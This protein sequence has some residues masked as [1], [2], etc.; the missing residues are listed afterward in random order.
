MTAH[1]EYALARPRISQVF[2]LAL[3]VATSE[4][5]GAKCLIAGEDCEVFDLVAA[6]VAAVCAVVTNKGAVAEEE[7]VG[8]GVEECAAGVASET[9]YMP[10]I[11]SCTEIISDMPHVWIVWLKLVYCLFGRAASN[12]QSYL[13][14]K[15]C[16]PLE[17]AFTPASASGRLILSSHI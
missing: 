15:P 1:T 4:T 16:P 8:V 14:R 7:E 9:I 11:A 12:R 3:A 10:S 17:S 13:I 6:C 2:N 5:G